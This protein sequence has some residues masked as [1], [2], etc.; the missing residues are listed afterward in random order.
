MIAMRPQTG[1]SMFHVERSL[2]VAGATREVE[3]A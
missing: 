3:S 2:F 1:G